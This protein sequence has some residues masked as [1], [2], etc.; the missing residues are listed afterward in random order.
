MASDSKTSRVQ[1]TRSFTCCRL[2]QTFPHQP[3]FWKDLGSQLCLQVPSLTETLFIKKDGVE[4]AVL[5]SV[6]VS[7][8]SAG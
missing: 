1:Y 8:G 3:F 6:T 7:L 2:F 4:L 5:R